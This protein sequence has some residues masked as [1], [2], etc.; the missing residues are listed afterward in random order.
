MSLRCFMPFQWCLSTTAMSFQQ[1]FLDTILLFILES[2][3]IFLHSE[4]NMFL[5]QKFHPTGMGEAEKLSNKLL[6]HSSDA[7]S[8][9]SDKVLKSRMPAKFHQPVR[10]T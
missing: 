2:A 8:D 9:F 3:F 10:P 1:N 7:G 4:K 5:F 6:E